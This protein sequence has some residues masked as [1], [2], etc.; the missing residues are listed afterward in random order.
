[1][2]LING[3]EHSSLSVAADSDL[4]AGIQRQAKLLGSTK[5]FSKEGGMGEIGAAL[6]LLAAVDFGIPPILAAQGRLHWVEQ[7]ASPSAATMLGMA[8][9]V[10]VR[11]A[12]TEQS[13]DRVAGVFSRDGSADLTVEFT[14]EEAKKAGLTGKD[15][16]QKYGQDMLTARFL[17]R[18]LRV[19]AAD[20]LAGVYSREELQDGDGDVA[21][22]P[23]QRGVTALK[24]ATLDF[25]QMQNGPEIMDPVFDPPPAAVPA[26]AAPKATPKAAAAKPAKATVNLTENVAVAIKEAVALT[27]E[28]GH[29]GGTLD[30]AATALEIYHKLNSVFPVAMTKGMLKMKLDEF[31][32]KN[33]TELNGVQ[34]MI[35]VRWADEQVAKQIAIDAAAAAAPIEEDDDS[36]TEVPAFDP[37]VGA[38]TKGKTGKVANAA[39]AENFNEQIETLYAQL[40][41]AGKSDAGDEI[42]EQYGYDS[43]TSPTQTKRLTRDALRVALHG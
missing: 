27:D 9:E 7:K 33:S 30:I 42:I 19:I 38:G 22:I 11:V 37:K 12:F 21:D 14:R 10:G 26:K 35:L 24:D 4:F 31:G 43:D 20:V 23:D 29:T 28:D 41:E 25:R 32:I 36:S 15:N 6:F 17:T 16:W 39:S 3:V 5:A 34:C 2:L 8:Y 40:S 18:G 13:V 1:M